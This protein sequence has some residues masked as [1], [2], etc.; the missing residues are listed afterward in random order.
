MELWRPGESTLAGCEGGVIAAA[1]MLIS[2]DGSG[3]HA[4][5]ARTDGRLDGLGEVANPNSFVRPSRH[6]YGRAYPQ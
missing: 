3:F 4:R 2:D 1:V 5:H 6:A